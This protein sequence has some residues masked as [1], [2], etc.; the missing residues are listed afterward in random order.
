MGKNFVTLVTVDLKPTQLRTFCTNEV[1][2]KWIGLPS[3][4]V[5]STS[6][7]SFKKNLDKHLKNVPNQYTTV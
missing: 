1:V 4:V 3:D 7:D 6:I 5:N 2:G